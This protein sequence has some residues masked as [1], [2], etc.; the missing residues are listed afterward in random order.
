MPTFDR[1]HHY[2]LVIRAYF[3][4]MNLPLRVYAIDISM[5]FVNSY[6]SKLFDGMVHFRANKPQFFIEY[7]VLRVFHRVVQW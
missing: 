5:E 2:R 3:H 6:T 7:G 1:N 4:K